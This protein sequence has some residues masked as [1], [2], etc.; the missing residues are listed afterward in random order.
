[1][2]LVTVTPPAEYPVSLAEAKS[3]CR[4]LDCAHDTRIYDYIGSATAAVEILT[5]MALSQ[6]TLRLELDGFPC[7]AIDLPVAPVQS[8][9]SIKYDDSVND[10]IT[11]VANTDYFVSLAGKYPK[12]VPVTTWPATYYNKP[13]SV[14][15]VMVCGYAYSEDIPADLKHAILVKTKELFDHGGETIVGVNEVMPSAN[16]VQALTAMH[17]RWNL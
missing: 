3:H 7:G 12:I 1:M 10:E 6:Q 2:P 13:N 11:L 17:R 14:R 16:T 8:I 9:T 15:I 5:A 4:V